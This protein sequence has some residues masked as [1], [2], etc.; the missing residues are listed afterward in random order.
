MKQPTTDWIVLIPAESN[1]NDAAAFMHLNNENNALCV[2][3][4]KKKWWSGMICAYFIYS[5]INAE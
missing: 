3:H 5:D 4:S 1:C 2:F